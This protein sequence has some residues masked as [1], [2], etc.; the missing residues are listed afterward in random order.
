MQNRRRKMRCANCGK[1]VDEWSMKEYGIGR[2]TV[3][4]CWDCYKSGAYNAAIRE[5]YR[6]RKIR[7]ERQK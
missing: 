2:K 4:V 7:E 6:N 3:R 1:D 5:M